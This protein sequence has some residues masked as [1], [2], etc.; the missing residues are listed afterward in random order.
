LLGLSLLLAVLLLLP[1]LGLFTPLLVFFLLGLVCLLGSRWFAPLASL[2]CFDPPAG[3]WLFLLLLLGLSR[4]LPFLLG[5]R[6]LAPP[7]WSELF[8][9]SC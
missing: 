2:S 1:G 9:S 3:S 4:F 7:A 6:W 5:V 8:G